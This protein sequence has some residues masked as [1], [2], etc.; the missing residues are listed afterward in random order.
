MNMNLEIS[1][2]KQIQLSTL[3]G[4]MLM[5]NSFLYK[6]EDYEIEKVTDTPKKTW[7][8]KHPEPKTKLILNRIVIRAYHSDGKFLGYMQAEGCRHLLV[9][10]DL[11]W[12]RK[13]W[14]D[15]NEALQAFGLEVREIEKKVEIKKENEPSTFAELGAKTFNKL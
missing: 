5:N 3:K 1:T 4:K 15:F 14:I 10:F 12:F 13:T 9:W 2:D 7:L 8:N 11:F 6:I